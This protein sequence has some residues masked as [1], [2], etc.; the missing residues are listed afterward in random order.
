M[1]KLNF[2]IILFILIGVVFVSNVKANT[3]T[4][5]TETSCNGKLCWTNIGGSF[6]FDIDDKWKPIEQ[7]FSLKNSNIKCNVISDKKNIAECLDWN[8]SSITLSL[9]VDDSLKNKYIPIK[10]WRPNLNI[11]SKEFSQDNKNNFKLISNSTIYFISSKETKTIT[12]PASYSDI[13]EF[14]ENSTLVILNETNNGNI[15][16]VMIAQQVGYFNYGIRWNIS[17]SST[18][19]TNPY[20]QHSM[21]LWN[22]STIPKSSTILYA[23]FSLFMFITPVASRNYSVYNTSLYNSSG[24]GP[25]VEGN[26][27]GGTCI[28]T[29]AGCDITNNMTW[30]NSMNYSV[31]Q[32]TVNITTV[33]SANKWIYWNVTDAAI[34]SFNNNTNMSLMIRENPEIAASGVIGRFYSK[35]HPNNI[36][37]R[38]QLNVTFSISSFTIDSPT[39]ITYVA[40]TDV[41]ANISIINND[42]NINWCY[43]SFDRTINET[44]TN[45]TGNWNYLKTGLVRGFHNLTVYCNFTYILSNLVYFSVDYFPPTYTNFISN[46]SNNTAINSSQIINVSSQ[47][48]DNFLISKCVNSSKNGANNWVNG[49]WVS[50]ST[51]GWVNFTILS[52][53]SMGYVFLTKIY[54]NDTSNN[55]N[56]TNVFQWFNISTPLPAYSGSSQIIDVS[57]FLT[58]WCE[59]N[60]TI[61]YNTT[62]N[63]ESVEVIKQCQYGCDSKLNSCNPNPLEA[64]LWTIGIIAGIIF[65]GVVFMRKIR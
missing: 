51:G 23:N 39:N 63:N 57:E 35:E 44:L 30:N 16:D 31:L 25:W 54:C 21:I 17:I 29:P 64:N 58:G 61:R 52:P 3:Y 38:P 36:T 33:G 48:T 32:D 6:A 2:L 40:N 50:N 42:T 4:Y 5:N 8:T 34:A 15:G 11:E 13:I 41:W 18:T 43:A 65:L 20:A 1:K 37:L 12:I 22:L 7:A 26:G 28:N 55:E 45:S 47:W 46:T 62:Y 56:V 14:G 60:N 53:S 59:N 24:A 10:V 19:S 49:T 9:K 27:N